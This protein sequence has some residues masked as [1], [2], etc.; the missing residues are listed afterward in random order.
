M[1]TVRCVFLKILGKPGSG[2]QFAERIVGLLKEA[3][4]GI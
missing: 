1:K 4:A 2:V 3:F